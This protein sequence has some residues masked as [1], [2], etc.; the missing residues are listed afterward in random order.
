LLIQRDTEKG[1]GRDVMQGTA[2]AF[3][4]I[5]AEQWRLCNLVNVLTVIINMLTI[6]KR[7]TM[8]GCWLP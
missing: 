5:V 7:D 8:A 3:L 1:A 4:L 2:H 6:V